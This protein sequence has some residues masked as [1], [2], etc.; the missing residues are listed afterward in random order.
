[1]KFRAGELEFTASVVDSSGARS[2]Q[3]GDQLQSLTVQFRAQKEGMHDAATRTATVCRGGGLFSL[4]DDDE[5]EHEWRVLDSSFTYVGS[6]PWGMHHHV[7]QI[8]EVK[9][10]TCERL[11]LGEVELAPYDYAEVV[12]DSGVVRL[13]ARA[14]VSGAELE[15]I[16][17]LSGPFD[18]VRSGITDMARK[19][20]LGGYVWGV[21]GDRLAV[22]VACEDV[23]EARVTVSGF[24]G[25]NDLEDVVALLRIDREELR[26]RRHARRRVVD[27]DGWPLDTG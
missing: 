15:V 4:A 18:V 1:V 12:S 23:A 14:L 3:S 6:E 2:R 16:S 9:R 17:R 24:T 25:G 20:C 21:R 26:R 19:M 13:A 10:L 5:P 8:A 27:V 7:W 22:V 11:R